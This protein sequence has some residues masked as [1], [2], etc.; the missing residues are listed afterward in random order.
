MHRDLKPPNL[1]VNDDDVLKIVDFGLAAAS[2][3]DSSRVTKTGHLI[4]TPSY[5]SPEQV[6]GLNVDFRTD[7]YSL[8]VV[9]YEIFTGTVPYTADNPM[10][11]LYQHIEG[12]KEPPRSRN[13][14]LSGDIEAVILKAMALRPDDRYQSAHEL[15][16]ALDALG[17]REAA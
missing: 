7:I 2:S 11:V 5:M 3:N 8:G 6:R 4:G 15:L 12:A 10:G 13:P 14:L 17:L 9:M 16:A 1:L